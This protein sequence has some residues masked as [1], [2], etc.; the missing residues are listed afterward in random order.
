[1]NCP[2]GV[3]RKGVQRCVS[4]SSGEK[5]FVLISTEVQLAQ[6]PCKECAGRVKPH[7][8]E[9]ER[10]VYRLLLQVCAESKDFNTWKCLKVCRKEC[11]Q[12]F[13]WKTRS[14]ESSEGLE[15]S[16]ELKEGTR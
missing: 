7:G 11:V 10:S 8:C 5:F 16:K 15:P 1:L 3:R 9:P 14:W 4:E 13:F 12:G 6:E 2:Q